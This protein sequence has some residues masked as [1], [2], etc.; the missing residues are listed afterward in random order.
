MTSR[1]YIQLLI[2]LIIFLFVVYLIQS[3]YYPLSFDNIFGKQSFQTG[4]INTSTAIT[5]I[6]LLSASTQSIVN[7][8]TESYICDAVQKNDGHN[9]TSPLSFGNHRF[10]ALRRQY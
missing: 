10:N 9:R 2:G 4:P 3:T 7:L 8:S 6:K 1:V 5:T